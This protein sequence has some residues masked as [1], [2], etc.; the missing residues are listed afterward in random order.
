MLSR[1]ARAT[2]AWGGRVARRGFPAGVPG[3]SRGLSPDHGPAPGFSP[4]G[5]TPKE[6]EAQDRRDRWKATFALAA[7]VGG[8]LFGFDVYL[9]L[10]QYRIWYDLWTLETEDP[11]PR[12][13][14]KPLVVLPQI[15]NPHLTA[16]PGLYLWG[17]NTDGLLPDRDVGSTGGRSDGTV[18]VPVRHLF[19]DGMVLQHVFLGSG[20]NLAVDRRGDVYQ[21]GRRFGSVE[22]VKVALGLKVSKAVASNGA[23]YL[24]TTKGKVYV[25]PETLA[26]QRQARQEGKLYTRSWVGARVPTAHVQWPVEG[27]RPAV[28]DIAV[29]DRHMVV[30][31]TDH[32]VYTSATG[33]GAHP[34]ASDT[35]ASYGQLGVVEFT[36][37][38]PLPP[39]NH[40]HEV[41]H[42]NQLVDNHTVKSRPVEQIAAGANHSVA[43]DGFGDVWAWGLNRYGQLG[44]SVSYSTEIIPFPR[45]LQIQTLVPRRLFATAVGVAAGGDTTFVTLAT[46]DV[47]RFFE[48]SVRQ[49]GGARAVDASAGDTLRLHHF[50]FGNGLQGTLGTNRYVHAQLAP[51]KVILLERMQEYSEAARGLV[52][53]PVKRWSVGA[54]HVLVTLDNARNGTQLLNDVLVWGGNEWGQLGTGR[55][56]KTCLPVNPPVVL[57]PGAEP[58]AQW[59]EAGA[60]NRMQVGKVGRWE[61]VVV[62]GAGKSGMFYS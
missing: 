32:K 23:V 22:P 3:P 48:E 39:P 49:Q 37:F 14:R 33:W 21:W 13:Q 42:L 55:R 35:S 12:K 29:G 10:P 4:R 34:S 47:N 53:V 16:T 36:Q 19:F 59:A 45:Q 2:A 41:V 5:P 54:D 51:A 18:K 28:A 1:L 56:V 50:A 46:R 40:L 15:V 52:L 43:R 61:Q 57:E 27:P 38:D 8:C 11:A 7:V 17:S 31:G 9:R 60:N 25:M 20:L 62:A 26:G 6:E 30:L 24:L 44:Q 58:A